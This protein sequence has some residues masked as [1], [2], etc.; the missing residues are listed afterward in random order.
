M[1]HDE[2]SA[3]PESQVRD[4]NAV[5]LAQLGEPGDSRIDD[6]VRRVMTGP[7][8]PAQTVQAWTFQSSI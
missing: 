2:T 8:N 4:L 5:S 6:A 3:T 1:E 7:G